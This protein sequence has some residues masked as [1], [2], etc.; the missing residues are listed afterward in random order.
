M[1]TSTPGRSVGFVKCD[2]HHS[3][4]TFISSQN[5]IPDGVASH[6]LNV[7]RTR[8][9][10]NVV[11]SPATLPLLVIDETDGQRMRL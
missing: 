2:S 3:A 9:F 1:A 5:D 6:M 4:T 8:I 11:V 10:Q 7:S